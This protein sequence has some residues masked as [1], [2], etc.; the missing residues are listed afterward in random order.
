MGDVEGGVLLGVGG[1]DDGHQV[2]AIGRV[3]LG[4]RREGGREGGREG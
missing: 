3:K 2:V 1:R 4:G